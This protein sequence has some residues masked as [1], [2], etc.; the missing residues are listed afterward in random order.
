[1]QQVQPEQANRSLEDVDSGAASP[2][3][4]TSRKI[5]MSRPELAG[6]EAFEKWRKPTF[7]DFPT[8]VGRIAW[9]NYWSLWQ[10][11]NDDLKAC[12]NVGDRS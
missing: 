7:I 4:P 3:S 12:Q 10:R 6:L 11:I 1:M 5:P 9:N 8:I 2:P